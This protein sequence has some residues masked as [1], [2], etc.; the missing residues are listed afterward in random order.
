MRIGLEHSKQECGHSPR[1]RSQWYGF[2]S[3]VKFWGH[4]GHKHQ[5]FTWMGSGAKNQRWSRVVRCWTNG[6]DNCNSENEHWGASA[7]LHEPL[8]LG[9]Q[10]LQH[11]GRLSATHKSHTQ[12]TNK[13]QAANIIESTWPTIFS[14]LWLTRLF[15]CPLF[16][17]HTV[18]GDKVCRN[19]PHSPQRSNSQ[20]CCAE[21]SVWQTV[22]PSGWGRHDTT[23]EHHQMLSGAERRP[24]RFVLC[25]DHFPLLLCVVLGWVLLSC[26]AGPKL[27]GSYYFP[28]LSPRYM[29]LYPAISSSILKID[30]HIEVYSH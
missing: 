14:A 22:Q 11:T 10:G 21:L 5:K 16:T 26:L 6:G 18:T 8:G 7:A 19:S 20:L 25:A 17:A 24:L 1:Q 29:P 15:V 13:T 23:A 12:N 9:L 2:R 27:I 28:S 3:H 30:T 4:S